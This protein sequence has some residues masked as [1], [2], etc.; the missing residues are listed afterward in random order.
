[1]NLQYSIFDISINTRNYENQWCGMIRA[2]FSK[3]LIS[4]PLVRRH[5]SCDVT[6]KYCHLFLFSVFRMPVTSNLFS[7]FALSVG[8]WRNWKSIFRE[9]VK[10]DFKIH[11]WHQIS[12]TLHLAG[13]KCELCLML[14]AIYLL[15]LFRTF[16]FKN[17][18]FSF[19]KMYFQFRHFIYWKSDLTIFFSILMIVMKSHYFLKC[20]SLFRLGVLVS[21]HW[22]N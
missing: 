2:R 18:Y 14:K 10:I 9:I 12:L 11:T 15:V 19:P 21:D 17:Y 1:M 3:M 13:A 4:M 8:L 5:Y 6:N 7:H 20:L 16:L 22:V